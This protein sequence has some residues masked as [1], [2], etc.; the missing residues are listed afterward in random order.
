MKYI[1]V[2]LREYLGILRDLQVELEFGS[3]SRS[4][5]TLGKTFRILKT[6]RSAAT[7]R[8]FGIPD[9]VFGNVEEALEAV[10]G[11]PRPWLPCATFR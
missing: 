5:R 3:L 10:Q 7:D 8:P 4:S 11:P 9:G 2:Q 6:L 1:I